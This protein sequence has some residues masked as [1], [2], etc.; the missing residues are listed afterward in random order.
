MD[1]LLV[2]LT[3]AAT[4]AGPAAP[5]QSVT[6]RGGQGSTTSANSPAAFSGSA[7]SRPGRTRMTPNQALPPPNGFTLNGFTV[8]G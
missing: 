7:G 5:R 4:L 6:N 1:T 3:L 8:N 2:A